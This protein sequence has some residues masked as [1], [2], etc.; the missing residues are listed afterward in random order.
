[1]CPRIGLGDVEKRKLLTLSG[2]ELRSL[3]R[4]ARS[5]SLYQLRYPGSFIIGSYGS[6]LQIPP[7]FSLKASMLNSNEINEVICDIKA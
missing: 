3:R 2:L 7:E 4:S 5:Q 6:K 1:V